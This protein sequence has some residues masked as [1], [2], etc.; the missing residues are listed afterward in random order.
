MKKIIVT[1]IIL[2]LTVALFAQTVRKIG[3]V[4][5]PARIGSVKIDSVQS[6]LGININ[7]N[8]N[9]TVKDIDG[10]IYKT[11]T[12]GNQ[13][14]MAENLRVTHYP[15]GTEILLVTDNTAWANLADNNTDEAYCFY[16]NDN[17]SD[18]GLLYTFAATIAVNWGKDNAVNQGVCPDGWHIPNNAEWDEL[19][20][21][22]GGSTVAGGKL[23]ETGTTHWNSPNTGATNESG[24]TAIGNGYRRYSDGNF[25]SLKQINNI[26]SATELNSTIAYYYQFRDNNSQFIREEN[27]TKSHGFSVRCLKD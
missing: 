25:Y 12:I 1:N 26:W 21:Y 17:T 7:I 19:S 14:W 4:E 11:V 22:L 9:I 24:F 18:Y 6:I 2:F 5:D 3:G 10:N 8:I 16:G 15:D 27:G 23:K 13:I 20:N